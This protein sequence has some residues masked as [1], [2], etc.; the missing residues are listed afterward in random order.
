MIKG[1][2]RRIIEIKTNDS[3]YFER[4]VLCLRPHILELPEEVA[5]EEASRYVA[6][7][8]PEYSAVKK[9]R[10]KYLR[11]ALILSAAVIL[12]IIFLK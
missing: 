12:L 9:H 11:A 2:N 5:E 3:A 4:A 10:L 8:M 6:M 7:I 1:V